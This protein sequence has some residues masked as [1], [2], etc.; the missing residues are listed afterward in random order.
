VSLTKPRAVRPG[1]MLGI[2]SPA[3]AVKAGFV[4]NGV[5]VLKQLGYRAKVFPHA[6]DHG[7]L[8]YAGSCQDRVSDLHA[9]FA[10][11]EVDAIVCTRGGWGAAE[12]LP[13]LDAGLIGDNPKAF[14]GYSDITSLHV[15]LR[16]E[17]NLVSF[18]APMVA[19]DF[20]R[21]DSVDLASWRYALEQARPWTLGPESGL[22]VLRGGM[23]EGVLDGGCISIYTEALG[24]PYAPLAHAE[25]TVLFLEDVGTKPYQWDRML[26]HLR[27]AGLLNNVAGIVFGDMAR[28]SE[29]EEHALL[30]ETIL[31][32]LRYFDGPIGIGLRSGHVAAGNIT[33][34]LGVRVRLDFRD[35]A[36]PQMHFVEAAVTV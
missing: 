34:P 30:D 24:T 6:L 2:I 11:A 10:D 20:V 5:E 16:R 14:V 35:A 27:Y 9:A 3:S 19:S 21:L 22:R 23:G 12:L 8:N 28:C 36:N 1:A 32:A 17:A 4:A 33:L 25:N 29:P 15:W 26:L 7:P 18:H 31:H 13:Y